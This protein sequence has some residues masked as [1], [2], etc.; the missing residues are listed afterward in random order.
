[1]RVTVQCFFV[2]E[3]WYGKEAEF[4]RLSAICLRVSP[5]VG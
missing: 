3:G 5:V 4:L 1:M 2:R